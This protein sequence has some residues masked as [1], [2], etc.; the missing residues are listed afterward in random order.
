MC[1]LAAVAPSAQDECAVCSPDLYNWA[2]MSGE[3][4]IC[5]DQ[6]GEDFSSQAQQI[7]MGIESYW[8][9]YFDD[10]EIDISF[11]WRPLGDSCDSGDIIFKVVDAGEMTNTGHSAETNFVNQNGHGNWVGINRDNINS[12]SSDR[13]AYLGAHELGHLLDFKDVNDPDCAGFTVMATRNDLPS[14]TL[15]GD[16]TTAT[17]KY[18]GVGP[19]EEDE[20]WEPSE[21]PEHEDCYEVSRA[22]LWVWCDESGCYSSGWTKGG[23]LRIDCGPP[24]I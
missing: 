12:E 5:F 4:T 17:V 1:A 24:P 19:V 20:W 16:K 9:P 14:V 2:E 15:C 6:S 23:F 10:A 8:A 22:Y 18:L 7:A 11:S 13:W 3:Y 21:D